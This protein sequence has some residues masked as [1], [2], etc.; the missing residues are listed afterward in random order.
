MI[1]SLDLL[2]EK[3]EIEHITL[4]QTALDLLNTD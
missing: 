3:G 1:R 4:K 2:L